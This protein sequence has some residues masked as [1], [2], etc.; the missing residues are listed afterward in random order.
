MRKWRRR[1]DM[2]GRRRGWG[3][4]ARG[5][6]PRWRGRIHGRGAWRRRWRRRGDF[7]RTDARPGHERRSVCERKR[8]VEDR[9]RVRQHRMSQGSTQCGFHCRGTRER[10]AGVHGDLD[11]DGARGHV[12]PHVRG[13]HVVRRARCDLRTKRLP[14]E[15]LDGRIQCHSEVHGELVG[16]RCVTRRR[17]EGRRWG[18][19]GRPYRAAAFVREAALVRDTCRRG[20]TCARAH[21]AIEHRTVAQRLCRG[22]PRRGASS[23]K[24]MRT[25]RERMK[26]QQ[27]TYRPSAPPAHSR[28]AIRARGF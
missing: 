27:P 12:E 2:E 15:A 6:R 3:G 17:G 21:A 19:R 23:T 1:R 4:R 25:R 16:L 10:R 26:Q 13:R 18:V 22:M 7:E 5:W 24:R 11:D 8:A 9:R 20:V 14:L 28:N